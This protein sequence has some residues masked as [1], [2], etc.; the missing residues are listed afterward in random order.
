MIRALNPKR[1]RVEHI[2]DLSEALL[3]AKIVLAHAIVFHPEGF[4]AALNFSTVKEFKQLLP[5]C[6]PVV[7]SAE[8]RHRS[9]A[10]ELEAR[11]VDEPFEVP[12]FKRA[13]YRA[14]SKTEDRRQRRRRP[15]A[16]GS[17]RLHRVILLNPSR[18]EG[19][20]MAAVLENELQA[21]VET[22][23][24]PRAALPHLGA[25][26]CVIAPPRSVLSTPAGAELAQE[27]ARLGVPL[28]P[29]PPNE[30]GDPSQAG[31]IAWAIAPRVRRSL[32]ARERVREAV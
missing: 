4:G 1:Y 6:T 20:V 21:S 19:S 25:A 16:S 15:T 32:H 12:L 24:S 18:N 27:M 8:A 5:R 13:V 30:G 29:L 26:D 2:F 14:V 23:T 22:V 10:L 3:R 17:R 28:V 11:F 31:Q 9:L 7:V